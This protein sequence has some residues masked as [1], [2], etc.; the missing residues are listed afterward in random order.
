MIFNV[1]SQMPRFVS[2]PGPL[3]DIFHIGQPKATRSFGGGGRGTN[4]GIFFRAKGVAKQ[5][6]CHQKGYGISP[7]D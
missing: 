7:S 1:A 6:S 4:L 2:D 5:H 3:F